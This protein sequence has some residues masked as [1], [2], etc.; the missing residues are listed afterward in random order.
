MQYLLIILGCLI[1]FGVVCDILKTTLSMQGSGWLTSKF[2]HFFWNV[3]LVLA[4]KDGKSKFLAK[5]GFYLLIKI[6]LIWVGLLVLSLFLLLLADGDS[7]VNSAK[8]PGSAL[9]KLYYSGFIISTLGIGDFTPSNNLWRVITDIY[10]FTG[11]ILITMSVT[12]FIPVLSAVI[13]QRKLGINLSSLGDSVEKIILNAWKGSDYTFF[14]L[15]LLNFSDALL[16]HNQNHRAYPVIHYF[17]NSD[18]EHSIVLQVARLNEVIFVMENFLKPEYS[19]PEQELSSIRTA[20]YNYI[21]V[22]AD[23][24]NIKVNKESPKLLSLKLLA[25]KEMLKDNW[26]NIDLK[27][28][29][30]QN[31]ATF[32]TLIE[33]DGWKWNDI[34]T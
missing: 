31:R 32:L 23:V 12:Y 19:I 33:R 6:I 4:G 1:Y 15:Q 2:S 16:E 30:Q 21:K 17:H 5:A 28:E 29:I 18:K 24:S 25:E 26:E 20:L 7:V 3:M 14:K 22:I 34:A 10:S 27:K 9:E 13:K 8:I 11:L